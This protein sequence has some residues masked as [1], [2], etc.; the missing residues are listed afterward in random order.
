MSVYF[1]KKINEMKTKINHADIFAI[2]SHFWYKFLYG[3]YVV[4]I[5][6]QDSEWG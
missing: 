3:Q 5:L 6:K 4:F 1:L 2:P